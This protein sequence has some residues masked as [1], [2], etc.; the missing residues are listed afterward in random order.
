MTSSKQ[1]CTNYKPSYLHK[2][3]S[4]LL[5]GIF[6]MQVTLS[7][8]NIQ[9]F[10]IHYKQVTLRHKMLEFL[11]DLKF[12]VLIGETILDELKMGVVKLGFS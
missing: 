6:S 2:V 8:L 9:L 12:A 7:L 4:I 10:Y 1:F 3:H 5:F 11:I